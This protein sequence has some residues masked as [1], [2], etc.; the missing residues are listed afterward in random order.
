[1]NA[2]GEITN[3]KTK[4]TGQATIKV[5][6]QFFTISRFIPRCS[7]EKKRVIAKAMNAEIKT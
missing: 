3:E 1:M 7:T 4:A 2:K 5:L 6:N